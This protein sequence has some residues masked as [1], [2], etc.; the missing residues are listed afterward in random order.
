[1]P[2]RHGK[3]ELGSKYFPAWFLGRNPD[4][5]VILTSYQAQFASEWGEKVRDILE[6]VGP[7]YFEMQVRSDHR[8]ADDW[9]TT[10]P[11]IGGMRTA[12]VQGAVT[13]RGAHLFIIDDPVKNDEEANSPRYREKTWDNYRSTAYT[14]LEPGGGII[15][16]QTRWHEDDL[17]GMVLKHAAET[18]EHWQLLHLPAL[19]FGEDVDALRRPEGAPLWPARYDADALDRIRKTLG[20]YRWSALY[21][22]QPQ[23]AD[24]GCFKRSWFRYWR[25]DGPDLF[26]LGGR[27]VGRKHC[28][29]F[30][31]VD[32]AFSLKKEADYTVVAA[33]AVT[34]KQELIL[35]DLHRERLEGPEIIRS[36]RRMY[37]KHQAQ[38]AGIE[39]VAAQALVIQA[40]RKE[41][42]TVRALRADKDKLSRAIPATVRMEAGQIYLPEG[43]PWLGELEHELLSFPK[44]SHDDQV[45]VLAYAAVEVQ[46]FGSA[47][48]PDSY[49]EARQYAETELAAEFFNRAEN[50]LFWVGDETDE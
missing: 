12:G 23:P 39:E 4:L 8:G 37:H 35:L 49:A 7:E 47:A 11:L 27:H 1:M 18:G 44:G 34:Q 40:A 32:L 48:E 13:G 9:N 20:S 43:A 5:R 42:L 17:M 2:P 15:I 16:T 21:Q 41:G 3:S 19:S 14:R 28:R 46:R 36:I 22:G 38:Y 50:P 26:D 45:D 10:D 29:V 33:W 30:L 25:A 6:D 31:T 24:G